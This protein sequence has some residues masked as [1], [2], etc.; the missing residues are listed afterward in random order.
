MFSDDIAASLKSKLK[1]NTRWRSHTHNSEDGV[2]VHK[3][4]I[5]LVQ[6]NHRMTKFAKNIRESL[7]QVIGNL[8]GVDVHCV[9]SAQG[10]M[11]DRIRLSLSNPQHSYCNGI[12]SSQEVL[13]NVHHIEI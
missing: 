12:G 10:N 13:N 8:L 5:L 1:Q 7:F 9:L 6:L 4:A 11:L 3:C 2:Q